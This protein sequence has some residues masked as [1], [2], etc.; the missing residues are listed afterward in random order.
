[1]DSDRTTFTIGTRKSNLAV[2]QTE[3]VR[4]ALQSKWSDYKFDIRTRDVA[5]DLNQT[6][7]LRNVTT[8][9]LWTEELEEMLIGKKLDIVVHSLKG[10]YDAPPCAFLQ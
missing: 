7:P 6:T 9:N 8:K 2:L 3:I 4:D 5:G 1:M 10:V